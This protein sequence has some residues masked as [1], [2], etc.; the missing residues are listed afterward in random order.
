MTHFMVRLSYVLLG[1]VSVSLPIILNKGIFHFDVLY[2]IKNF[3]MVAFYLVMPAG[4][5][6]LICL[7]KILINVRKDKVFEWINVRYLKIIS[8]CCFYASLVGLVSFI[9]VLIS[10]TMFETLFILSCGEVFMALV[11]RVVKNTMET[12]IK[13]KEENDLTI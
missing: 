7:D 10:G 12:A 11:V 5:A 1:I 8:Y 6:A 13:I 2:S 9:V 3:A 4:Y